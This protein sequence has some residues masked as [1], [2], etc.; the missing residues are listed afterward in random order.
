MSHSEFGSRIKSNSSLGTDH[1]AAAP[2][3]VFGKNVNPGII[4][5][6]PLIPAS[7]TV[8]DNIPMQYDFRQ[9]YASI[10]NDWF[11]VP[12][13]QTDTDML[14]KHFDTLAIFKQGLDVDTIT[15]SELMQL[16]NYPNPFRDHTTIEYNCPGGKVQLHLYDSQGRLLK[17]LV[18][19]TQGRGRYTQV[20][21]GSELA[22]GNYYYQLV[23]EAGQ[24]GRTLVKLR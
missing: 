18:N 22:A 23:T 20:L 2:L 5:N 9:V 16:S 12:S 24:T 6:N 7:V 14:F 3:I 4:G 13:A 1:G 21:D 19:E 15:S 11:E 10:L 17:T 8:N